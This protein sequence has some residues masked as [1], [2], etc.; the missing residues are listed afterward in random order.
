M[1]HP[2]VT[3]VATIAIV[4]LA[5]Y[6]SKSHGIFHGNDR[7]K[8]IERRPRTAGIADEAISRIFRIIS[9]GP[10]NEKDDEQLVKLV[11]E[12][13]VRTAQSIKMPSGSIEAAARRAQKLVIELTAAYTTAI[14]KSKSTEEA[15]FN[16]M[17]FQN[18]VQQIVDFIKSGQFVV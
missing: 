14:Y 9:T 11:K 3:K 16:F 18:S 1:G 8:S 2:R 7:G 15:R 10:S 13:I 4:L 17:R 12:E 6:F 5:C